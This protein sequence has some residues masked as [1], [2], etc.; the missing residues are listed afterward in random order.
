MPN[1]EAAW[2]N[3]WVVPQEQPRSR[4]HGGADARI[5]VEASGAHRASNDRSTVQSLT[6]RAVHRATDVR[7]PVAAPA[8]GVAPRAEHVAALNRA[9]AGS[10]QLPLHR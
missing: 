1:L 4:A 2:N 3:S 7:R 5:V 9:A 6:A 10:P 8:A